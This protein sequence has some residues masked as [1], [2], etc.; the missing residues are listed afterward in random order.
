MTDRA[1]L[2]AAITAAPEEDDLPR[3][4]FADWLE[5]HGDPEWAFAVRVMCAAPHE[6]DAD[7][8]V[9]RMDVGRP[10]KD[11]AVALAWLETHAPYHLSMLLGGRRC[12]QMP[13]EW[14]W[15]T[16][17][18]ELGLTVEWRRGFIAR[19]RGPLEVARGHLPAMLAAQP[20]RRA[21]ATD[22]R[23]HD[24][25]PDVATAI[26]NRRFAWY[27]RRI[28]GLTPPLAV[29]PDSVYDHLPD[30]KAAFAKPEWAVDALS[31][32][33]LGEARDAVEG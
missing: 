1:A 9:E 18:P 20:V 11:V 16:S 24:R 2:L 15:L 12:E 3:L 28:G 21:E 22:R 8:Q 27:Q 25:F 5:E 17:C 4:V 26:T 32:A 13:G 10:S 14:L 7:V 30:G 6:F 29:L 19:V 23:P 31:A 33:L